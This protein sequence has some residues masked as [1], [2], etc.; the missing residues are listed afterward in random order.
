[1]S[2]SDT[3]SDVEN[4]LARALANK[5]TDKLSDKD[6]EVQSGTGSTSKIPEFELPAGSTWSKMGK[7]AS[8]KNLCTE[9]AAGPSL[10]HGGL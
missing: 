7:H 1:M 3:D 6:K 5:Q 8:N 4:I 9:L 2:G 10:L